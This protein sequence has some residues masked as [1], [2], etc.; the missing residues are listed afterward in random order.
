M[1]DW[2]AQLPKLVARGANPNTSDYEPEDGGSE[3]P[4][5]ESPA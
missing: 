5:T 3:R 2:K 1:R 4:A